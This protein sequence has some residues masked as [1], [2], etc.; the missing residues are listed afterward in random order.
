MLNTTGIA[1]VIFFVYWGI[2]EY[3]KASGKLEKYNLSSFG[4]ILLVRTSRG[5]DFL[6]KLSKFKTFWRIFANLGIPAVFAGMLFMFALVLAMDYVIL[7][8]PPQPSEL[9]HPRSALL[10]PGVNPY[11]PLVW[12]L[13]GLAVTLI[14][15][16]FSH[17]ILCRVEGVKVRALG[18]V[19]A[20]VPIGGFAEPDEKQLLGKE[21]SLRAIQRIRIFSAGV[22]SNFFVAAIAFS[23][24]FYLLSFLSPVVTVVDVEENTPAFGLVEKGSVITSINGIPIQGQEDVERILKGLESSDRVLIQFKDGKS[25]ELP[26][27]AGIKIADTI[28]GYPAEAAGLKKGMVIVSVNGVDTPTLTS[29]QKIMRSTKPGETIEL[30]VFSGGKFEEIKVTLTKAPEGEYGFLGVRIEGLTYLSGL[31]LGYSKQML[32]MLKGIPSSLTSPVGWLTIMSMPFLF[33][34]GFG[35]E[36]LNF[37]TPTGFWSQFGNLLFYVLNALYWIAWLNFYV[38][39]F[40][41]LP[42]V[43]LDGGRVFK[44]ALSSI[45]ARRFGDRGEAI[46]EFAV[47]FLA[48]AI[49]SSIAISIIIPNLPLMGL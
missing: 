3:L 8:S 10:I 20:L 32:D 16:E 30:R 18:V 2:V 39:L 43:P 7:T 14:V 25:V 1:L 11:I 47:K 33:F 6:D 36:M 28:S 5:L 15:H 38:G 19:L 44:E 4:P 42:A 22:I 40:N 9:T 49:F 17:A 34:P 24:F 31:R 13:I 29:F 26:K 23:L 27:I 46:S 12:G 41:C 21:S 45:L 35:G 37:F 48:I